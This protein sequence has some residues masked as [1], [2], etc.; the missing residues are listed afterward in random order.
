MPI[1]LSDDHT[2]L[3]RVARSFLE[4][5]DAMAKA[6]ATL[7]TSTE[8]L[9]DYWG[10][11]AS[12]GWLSIHLPE[13]HGGQGAGLEELAIL[14]EEL[15][16]VVGAGAFLPSTA[17]G[18]V[19]DACGSDAQRTQHLGPLAEGREVG[20]IGLEGSLSL[21]DGMLSGTSALVPSAAVATVA[22]LGVGDD[23][24]VVDLASERVSVSGVS[25]FDS[26]RQLCDV[27]IE[28]LEIDEAS[29]LRGAVPTALRV[30]RALAAAEAAG[31]AHATT[32]M[33]VAYAKVREQ[34]GQIIGAFQAVKH[35]CANMLVH[36]EM[37]TALAWEAVQ[38]EGAAGNMAAAAAAGYG[39]PGAVWCAQKNIQILGGIGFTWEHDAHLFLRRASMMANL[40]HVDDR[41][42]CDV[43]EHE[44]AGTGARG[45]ALPQEAE[46]F[47]AQ[48]AEVAIAISSATP[49]EAKAELIR[50]GYYMAHLP[51]PYG[52]GAGPI[53]QLV[54][55][56]ELGA[57][58]EPDL[59]VG[60][61]IIPTLIGCCDEAQLERWILPSFR[62]EY[63]WC[64]L[65]SEPNAGSDAAAIS[66]RG[67]KV[68]GGWI[69]SGQKVWTSGAMECNI[70]LATVRT[71]P[72]APKHAGV[73]MMA[74]DLTS[75]AIEVRPLRE[76]SG[77][78]LF[79]EVFLNDVFVPD[80]DVVG[81][82]GGGWLVARA[83]LGNERV[84]IGGGQ[85]SHEFFAPHLIEVLD[86]C[87]P[88][89]VGRSREVGRLLAEAHGM[90]ALNMRNVERAIGGHE[91]GP[92][93]NIT[94]LL[95]AEHAQRVTEL[96]F[97]IADGAA[98]RGEVPDLLHDLMFTRCLSIAGGT[99]EISRNQIAERILGLPRDKLR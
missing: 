92:E 54:I 49:E 82:V 21:V 84:T 6:R 91:P 2:E 14:V 65:F 32:D 46:A 44:R 51:A 78:S 40:L 57:A 50:T 56:E 79:N 27:T 7:D 96:G 37:A 23:L 33:A 55:E 72:E 90:H 87:A 19:I 9:V 99:S 31:G 34:F 85:R 68:E 36:A 76:I 80:A 4:G 22:L 11:L 28:R 94:K 1:A 86:A 8:Q 64:Q 12:M 93:G 18:A 24:V 77:D 5:T 41:A 70:G 42:L 25:S 35:H 98:L 10:E 29:V 30:L 83:T 71:D 74:V 59:G 58:V 39:L 60:V 95:S 89:D 61:W 45:V 52:R 20:T 53:E 62:G 73:T 47:R 17:A 26:T 69:V 63:R 13:S 43:V 75:S 81:E 97:S 48:V 16:R 88:G 38:H 3:A 15:G 67:T 66:T